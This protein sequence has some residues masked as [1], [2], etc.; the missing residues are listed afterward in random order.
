MTEP[1]PLDFHDRFAALRAK[2]EEAKARALAAE[3]VRLANRRP[4]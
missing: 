1:A 4:G 2:L 3:L